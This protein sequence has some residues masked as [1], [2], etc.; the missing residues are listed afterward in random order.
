MLRLEDEADLQIADMEK[1]ESN[2]AIAVEEHIKFLIATGAGDR[3]TA[4]R[5][6]HQAERT[7]GDNESLCYK[8]GL[9][10]GYFNGEKK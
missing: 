8:L 3:A 10:F 6:M 4:I 1:M 2:A 9:K 5:W 7:N